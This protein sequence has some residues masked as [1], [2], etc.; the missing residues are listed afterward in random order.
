M[1]ISY[2]ILVKEAYEEALKTAGSLNNLKSLAE[3]GG[4][5]MQYAL[6]VDY[7]VENRPE[8]AVEWWLKAANQGHV[9]AQY[10]IGNCYEEGLVVNKDMEKQ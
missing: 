10:S 7:V 9:L 2:E 4:S 1:G 3:V 8:M 6:D 5:N